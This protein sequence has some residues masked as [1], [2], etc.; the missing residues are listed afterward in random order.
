MDFNQ[1]ELDRQRAGARRQTDGFQDADEL[2]RFKEE[3]LRAIAPLELRMSPKAGAPYSRPALVQRTG[4]DVL[5][6][7]PIH[8][9]PASMQRSSKPRLFVFGAMIAI[10]GGALIGVTIAAADMEQ[11]TLADLPM[12]RWLTQLTGASPNAVKNDETQAV[13]NDTT[14]QA[15]PSPLSSQAPT[16]EAAVIPD[17]PPSSQT[18][19]S[20]AEPVQPADLAQPAAATSDHGQGGSSRKDENASPTTN[21]GT[22]AA[23]SGNASSSPV[24]VTE[25]KDSELYREF[26]AWQASREKP[27][28]EQ[29]RSAP[30][31][32]RP[33]GAHASR[34]HR[35]NAANAT[36][37]RSGSSSRAIESLA[38]SNPKDKRDLAP[39]S[40]AR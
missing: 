31:F 39:Q 6:A 11:V 30:S 26:I 21:E 38:R 23:T 9:Y 4:H 37:N 16:T 33:A 19:S 35:A 28:S 12:A 2:E 24:A 10:L 32:K 20:S 36:G 7:V 27:Q 15:E 29:R 40:A 34:T 1:H 22:L 5:A 17:H 14:A 13:L 8:R 18:T 3:L 25:D